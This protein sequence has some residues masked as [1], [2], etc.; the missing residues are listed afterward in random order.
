MISDP[1]D[2]GDRYSFTYPVDDS[3][4]PAMAV[5]EAVSWVKGEDAAKLE[6]LE[7]YI[8]TEALDALFEKKHHGNLRRSSSREDLKGPQVSFEYEGFTVTLQPENVFIEKRS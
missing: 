8:D 1:D 4:P 5:I 6:P 3:Y 2:L 7:N